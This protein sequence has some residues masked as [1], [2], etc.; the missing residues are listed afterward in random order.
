M[1]KSQITCYIVATSDRITR[2][3]CM[4]AAI[5]L[6]RFLRFLG[7][8]R[9][10]A[11]LLENA[12]R[13]FPVGARGDFG[14]KDLRI[15]GPHPDKVIADYAAYLKRQGRDHGRAPTNQPP[16]DSLMARELMSSRRIFDALSD[17]ALMPPRLE[18]VLLFV[19][20]G[21]AVYF[22]AK[23]NWEAARVTGIMAVSVCIAAALRWRLRKKFL[24]W[25]TMRLFYAA[26][27]KLE[28]DESAPSAF[29]ELPRADV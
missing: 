28:R 9:A 15:F 13:R 20:S 17:F 7:A 11:G 12:Y 2:N 25:M 22:A 14:E 18:G 24:D 26:S 4:K 27:R 10:A 23:G 21:L 6:S 29:R 8:P 19:L 3:G 5:R 1:R 16:Q